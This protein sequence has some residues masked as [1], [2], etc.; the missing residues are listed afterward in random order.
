MIRH[1]LSFANKFEKEL[2][3]TAMTQEN[4]LEYWNSEFWDSKKYPFL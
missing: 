1:G 3:E 4:P 2:L